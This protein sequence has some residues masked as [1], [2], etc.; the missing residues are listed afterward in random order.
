MAS[1]W[2]RAG[3]KTRDE[4]IP[5]VEEYDKKL[6]QGTVDK[7]C[8]FTR[9]SVS[10]FWKIMDKWYNPEFFEQDKDGVWHEKFSVGKG[11]L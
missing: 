3:L 7:F 4:M 5:V 10:E 2:I 11:L 6:D 9:I 8:E 1:R